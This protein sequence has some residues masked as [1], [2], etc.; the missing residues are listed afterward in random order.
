MNIPPSLSIALAAACLLPSA[1]SFALSASSG[2]GM[3]RCTVVLKRL[4]SADEADRVSILSW[5]QGYLAGVASVA[6]ALDGTSDVEVP[7]YDELQ[8]RI[9]K[10]CKAEPGWDL[11]RVARRLS[12]GRI[13]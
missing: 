2:P 13:R 3:M 8:P 11:S 7:A 12:A 4:A 5:A 10:L 9:L 1:P 6:S